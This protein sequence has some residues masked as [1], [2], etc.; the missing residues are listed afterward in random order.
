MNVHL[1]NE[2]LRDSFLLLLHHQLFLG[3]HVHVQVE[4]MQS[5]NFQIHQIGATTTS[6]PDANTNT[7]AASFNS[8]QNSGQNNTYT[9]GNQRNNSGAPAAY[10]NNSP[11][12][13]PY[14]TTGANQSGDQNHQH[15]QRSEFSTAQQS[16]A[17]VVPN[18]NTAN[19][20]KKSF[21]PPSTASTA[22]SLCPPR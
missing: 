20:M 22:P 13:T 17:N 11:N 12:R 1:P 6:E 15:Q 14:A 7:N 16:S 10:G 18:N 19:M 8:T 5:L 4:Q 3:K 9:S 2:F 21:Q